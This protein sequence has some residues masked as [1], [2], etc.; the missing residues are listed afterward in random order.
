MGTSNKLLV[1]LGDGATTEAF[2]HPC[3]ANANTVTLT[4]N[5]GEA[6]VLDCD[7]PLGAAAIIERWATTQDTSL[8]IS[9]V[10]TTESFPTWRAWADGGT[11]K[12]IRVLF[13]ETAA[14]NGGYWQLPAILTTFEMG[15]ENKG[16]ISFTASIVGAG[17]RTWTD[18]S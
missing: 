3:G 18:A 16:K 8:N 13:D 14:N 17:A 5:T 1:Y 7:D 11:T 2:A 9:G 15:R 10:V 6:E 12:N 4:T